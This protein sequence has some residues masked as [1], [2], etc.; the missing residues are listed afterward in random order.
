MI[1]LNGF[2]RGLSYPCEVPD[3][4]SF[5][6]V[7]PKTV[8]KKKNILHPTWIQVLKPTCSPV[9][10]C[11]VDMIGIFQTLKNLTINANRSPVAQ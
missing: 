6:G 3:E 5:H 7:F 10:I 4:I 9:I 8:A 1:S 11:F 2:L